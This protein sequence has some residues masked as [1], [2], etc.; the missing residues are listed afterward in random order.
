[1]SIA[2]ASRRILFGN[3]ISQCNK[4]RVYS[5]NLASSIAYS[6]Q[7]ALLLLVVTRIGGL[8]DAGRFSIYYIT[9]TMLAS[10]GSFSMRNYQVSDAKGDFSYST[11]YGS[12]VLTCGIMIALCAGYA[13]IWQRTP[14]GIITVLA[15]GVYRATDGIEDVFHGEIQRNGRLDAASVGRTLRIAISFCAFV[16]AYVLT[17]TMT[18]ASISMASCSLLIVFLTWLIFQGVYPQ[19]HT[20]IQLSNV[21]RLL[22]LCLPI[23]LSAVLYNY[24]A[25]LPRYAIEANMS[26]DYQGVFNILFMPVFAV[27]MLSTVIFNPTVADMGV[28]WQ[29][30]DIP[31]LKHLVI[32]QYAAVAIITLVCAIA[33]FLLGCP[34][35][36]LIFGV[37]LRGWEA[38]LTLLMVLGG[39]SA[40]SS[41]A[42]VMLTVMRMQIFIVVGYI[43]A[44]LLCAPFLSTLVASHGLYGAAYGYGILI[45]IT[46]VVFM[47]AAIG[48]VFRRNK[49]V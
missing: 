29:S 47:A 14:E 37:D 22:L 13:L 25:N 39:I 15:L 31:K 46:L 27:D 7:S 6:L 42:V 26:S 21:G 33:A 19:L 41:F 5:W 1:M 3:D 30:G 17:R 8:S 23:C 2:E 28:A 40:L 10:V 36:G 38:L 20:K 4:A 16:A 49:N 45:G 24:I 34:I 32:R 48:S 43:V 11:Y 18:V 44:I 35:L 9:T 12:R